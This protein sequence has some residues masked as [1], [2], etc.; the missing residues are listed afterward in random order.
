[1][2]GLESRGDLDSGFLLPQDLL[3]PIYV[4]SCISQNQSII[5]TNPISFTYEHITYTLYAL[6]D[7]IFTLLNAS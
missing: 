7:Q 5:P 1:M 4:T 2:V 3:T 6:G